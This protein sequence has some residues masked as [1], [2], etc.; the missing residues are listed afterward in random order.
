MGDDEGT[1]VSNNH[2][3]P[4]VLAFTLLQ[5]QVVIIMFEVFK[6]LLT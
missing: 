1:L 4:F 5:N 6:P 2:R 3:V